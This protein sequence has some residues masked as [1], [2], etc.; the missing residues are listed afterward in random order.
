MIFYENIFPFHSLSHTLDPISDLSAQSPTPMHTHTFGHHMDYSNTIIPP[1]HTNQHNIPQYTP[2]MNPEPQPLRHS[3]RTRR[4]PTYLQDYHYHLLL[5]AAIRSSERLI[6]TN[7]RYLISSILSYQFLSLSY[8]SVICNIS[9]SIEPKTYSQA[10]KSKW[11]RQVVKV[12]IE[13]LERNHTW[14][15]VGLP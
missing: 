4:V 11:W 3:N 15:L 10:V 13:A 12:E 9:S 7:V 8:R 2:N 1:P 14:K 5:A 6:D